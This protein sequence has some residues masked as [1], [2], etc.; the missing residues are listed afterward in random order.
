[1]IT[2]YITSKPSNNFTP[3]IVQDDIVI[4]LH[5]VYKGED[6]KSILRK[7][8]FH[9]DLLENEL[10]LTYKEMMWFNIFM[11]EQSDYFFD[12]IKLV[13]QQP[14]TLKF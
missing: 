12:N 1:M 14:L 9:L 4:M 11:Q 2:E 5:C 3:Y 8:R 6:V 7:R 13:Y 10:N